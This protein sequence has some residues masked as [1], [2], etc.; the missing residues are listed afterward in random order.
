MLD[1]TPY[2]ES[3]FVHALAAR[4]HAETQLQ[5]KNQQLVDKARALA[6]A[7]HAL[8]LCER[9]IEASANAMIITSAAAPDFVIEYV[10]PAFERITGYSAAEVLG[11]NCNF[12]QGASKDQHGLHEIRAAVREQRAGN[13]VLCNYRK[14][15]SLF[16]NHLYVAPVFN[17][18]GVV[19]HFVASQYDITAAKNDEA[20]LMH[21]A[22]HDTL[23]GLPNRTFLR[24]SVQK[25][26]ES[27]C[28]NGKPLWLMFVSLDGLSAIND[29]FGHSGSDC[30]LKVIAQRLRE[31]VC[32]GDIVTHWC[33][34]SF[35]IVLAEPR[36]G[37][38][39]TATL[40]AILAA[41]NVAVPYGGQDLFLNCNIGVSACPQQGAEVDTLIDCADIALSHAKREGRNNFRFHSADMNVM[42][43][44]RLRI[45]SELRLAIEREEFVLHYQPQVELGSGRIV[46]MEAL[47]RWQHPQRG[48]VYPSDFIAIAE[49][50]GLIVPIGAWVLRSA[51]RQNRQW[52]RDGFAPM[53]VAV[54]VSARQFA[55]LDLAREIAAVLAEADLSPDNLEIEVTES[56]IMHDVDQTIG[57]LRE[58]KALGV[59]ISVDDFGTG[60]SSL[61]YLKLLPIDVLK[62]DRAFVIDLGAGEGADAA[63]VTSIITLAHALK[64]KV[65]AEGVETIEQLEFLRRNDCDEMQG[66]Y[67]SK[68][69]GVDAFAALLHTE[70]H[71][72]FNSADRRREFT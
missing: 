19:S 9:A 15:G 57:T 4:R 25:A 35:V 43:A 68:P 41:V 7:T 34:S 55:Q 1:A 59:R 27:G 8:E 48:L 29:N 30:V 38:L 20:K 3:P 23:T 72:C 64:L 5:E 31:V 11:R 62:I 18:N 14:D 67:F 22:H 21:M 60:Y 32:A 12:L 53:R 39:G 69:V 2:T 45:E 33:G 46:G 16:W 66:Y 36:Q 54:N 47:L 26:M 63:I 56:L 65:I 70:N 42:A 50:T 61:A 71:W 49:E 6:H 17:T 58:L 24:D 40:Q 51:C 13:A 37:A 44:A 10:N 52:Q 28:R